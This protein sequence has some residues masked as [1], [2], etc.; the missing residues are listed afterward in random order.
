MGVDTEEEDY[1]ELNGRR[2]GI[3]DDGAPMFVSGQDYAKDENQIMHSVRW[4]VERWGVICMWTIV[5]VTSLVW[6]LV[7]ALVWIVTVQTVNIYP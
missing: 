6:I 3:N 5:V 2:F 7:T 1:I 4:Y